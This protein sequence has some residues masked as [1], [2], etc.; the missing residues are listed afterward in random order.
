[1]KIAIV[2]HGRFHAFDLA[3]ALLAR[4]HQVCVF[5][6]YPKQITRKWGLPDNAVR[7]CL[8]HGVLG[9]VA[10]R[11]PGD[12]EPTL[13]S[14]FGRWAAREVAQQRWDVVHAFSGVAEEVFRE[15]EGMHRSLVR[16][17]AHIL[18]QDRL[19]YEEE[20]RAGVPILRPSSW[21]KGREIREYDFADSI[22][23][24]SSFAV[25]SFLE[26]GIPRDKLVLLPLGVD[27]SRFQATPESIAERCRRIRSV[28]PLR[29]LF[30]GT[31]SFQ[32][33]IL[34]FAEIVRRLVGRFHFRFIGDAPAESEHMLR[35]LQDR[36][37]VIP[38]QSQFELPGWYAEAD[39]F[40]FP[41]IQ[42]GFALVLSQALAAGLPILATRNCSSRDT[43][44]TGETGWVLPI[45]RPDAFIESL[46]WCDYNREA[47]AKMVERIHREF[48]PRDWDEV[49]ADF[50]RAYSAHIQPAVAA[51]AK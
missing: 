51:E 36:L 6:N 19:L 13:H 3:R 30:A 35:E 40:L 46:E 18:A 23:V 34:D 21:I 33:G 1:L 17:S 8:A 32:K 2:V 15:T 42:D 22:V 29:V 26:H 11:M 4:G 31:F 50:E 37:E 5:T 10:S 38:R 12:H 47:L 41:T 49:A 14:M 25:E 7:S 44:R 24:L 16:G 39:L 27:T 9:R 43:I 45:R 48:R 28:Q 20:L